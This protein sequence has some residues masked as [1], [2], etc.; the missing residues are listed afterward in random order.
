MDQ[1]KEATAISLRQVLLRTILIMQ[2]TLRT[3]IGYGFG[4]FWDYIVLPSDLLLNNQTSRFHQWSSPPADP[5]PTP[6][7]S[8]DASPP[9]PSNSPPL[10]LRDPFHVL[11]HRIRRR[12]LLRRP[13]G[14][15]T[16]TLNS[17]ASF[18]GGGSSSFEDEEPLLDELGIHPDQ[19]WKK[20]R[21]ILNPF[22]IKP[23]RPPRLG[24]IRP[25]LPLPR[26]L[27]IPAPRGKIQFGVILGWIVVSSIFLYAG[28]QHARGEEWESESAHVE[29]GR[30]GFGCGGVCVVVDEGLL[31]VGCVFG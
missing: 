24:S 14:P 27:P 31:G 8:N 18:G 3:R 19:I 28:V 29:L 15:F 2:Q 11:R 10:L 9:L 25:D 20:T 7:S 4:G 16:G 12:R 13:A 30:L 21:S 17:S 1:I 23:N 5:P 26:A 6:T 22:R